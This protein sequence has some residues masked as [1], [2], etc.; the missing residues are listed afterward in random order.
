MALPIYFRVN[1][2]SRGV[3]PMGCLTDD[4]LFSYIQSNPR[5]S[6]LGNGEDARI[7]I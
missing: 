4:S 7:V 1:F 5:V 2:M 3:V 6:S